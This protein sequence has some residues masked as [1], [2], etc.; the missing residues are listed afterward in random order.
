[1]LAAVYGLLSALAWGGGDFAGGLSSRRNGALRAVF[2]ADWVGIVLLL[3]WLALDQEAFPGWPV[4]SLAAVAGLLGTLGL[5]ALYHALATGQMSIATPVSALLAAAIPVAVATF[6]EGLPG[7]FQ[8]A[9]FVLALAAVWLVSSS[10]GGLPQ[11]KTLADLRLPLLS[12][13]GFGAYFV[14]IEG[15]TQAAT[16]WPMIASRSSGTII[17]LVILLARRESL[18]IVRNTWPIA[19]LN[20]GLDVVGNT[21]YVLAAQTGRLDVAAVLAS[22]YPGG[23]VMLAWWFLKERLSRWQW[24]GIFLALGAIVL[25]TVQPS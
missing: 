7:W 15:A 23:T 6:T 18:G 24:L 1:M 11:F 19:L 10:E 13:I 3:G 21:F 9:G 22:L 20:A 5:L 16:I 8:V 12:G 14:L 2:Y 4:M 17:L 25:L